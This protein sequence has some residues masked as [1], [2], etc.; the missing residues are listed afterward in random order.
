MLLRI[1]GPCPKCKKDDVVTFRSFKEDTDAYCR[2]CK[3]VWR[4]WVSID[5]QIGRLKH[6]GRLIA[7]G[8]WFG[9]YFVRLETSARIPMESELFS[10]ILDFTAQR[11]GLVHDPKFEVISGMM[12]GD[13]PVHLRRPRDHFGLVVAGEAKKSA[14]NLEVLRWYKEFLRVIFFDDLKEGGKSALIRTAHNSHIVGKGVRTHKEVM[15]VMARAI[16]RLHTKAFRYR[17]GRIATMINEDLPLS[18]TA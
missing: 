7:A 14:P 2:A 17:D 4:D 1:L 6:E 18:R 3:K 8:L 15:D 11:F 10:M 12:W 9:K 16:Q 13:S 5:S